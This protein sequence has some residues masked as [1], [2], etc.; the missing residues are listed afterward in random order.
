MFHV[1]D[2]ARRSVRAAKVLVAAFALL[3]TAV[4][5]VYAATPQWDVTGSY[6]VTFTCVT[7]CAGDYVHRANVTSENFTTGDFSGTGY[8]IADPGYTWNISG[9]TLANAIDFQLLYTGTMAGYTLD[10]V[11]TINENGRMSGTATDSLGRT[12]TWRTA[13][14]AV[15][16]LPGAGVQP[17]ECNGTYTNVIHGTNNA[18][19][20]NGT[21][22][23]DLIFGYGGNDTING[24]SGNDCIVAGMGN[25]K[26]NGG[27]GYDI[28]LGQGGNDTRGLDGGS[29]DDEV[30]GG[31][32]NDTLLGSTGN[33][34]LNGGAG[35][36]S[37]DGGSGVDDCLAETTARCE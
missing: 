21:S 7:G 18:E 10:A 15:N 29:A 24:E 30:Y 12:F 4:P 3:V 14:G 27:S 1:K 9:N 17:S 28:V 35:S 22:A 34:E 16:E 11:G 13:N 37:A 20:L 8:Y 19:T 2:W 5:S 33:D 26:A 6:D 36:D 31:L 25:D 32:G 23:N